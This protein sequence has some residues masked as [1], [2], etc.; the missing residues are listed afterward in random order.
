MQ[1]SVE[2]FKLQPNKPS[3]E[4]AKFGDVYG[5]NW[6]LL[7][8]TSRQLSSTVERSALLQSHYLEHRSSNNILQIFDLWEKNLINPSSLLFFLF[9]REKESN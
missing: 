6:S 3:K 7:P 9:E 2:I 4:L 5:T 1:I 8:R